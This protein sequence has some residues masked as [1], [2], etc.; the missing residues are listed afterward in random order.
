M[1]NVLLYC[2]VVLIWGPTWIMIKYQLGVVPVEASV[3][4]RFMIAA[5]LMFAWAS[6]WRLP[7]RF[8][9][10][11][12]GF[13]ALQGMLIFSIN[14]YLFYLAGHH[15]ATGLLAVIFSTASAL[16]M[17]LNA[18]RA[19]QRPTLQGMVGA[20]LGT[21]GIGTIFWPE[22]VEVSARSGASTGLA[23]G[24]GG[25]LC[26]ALGGMVSARNHAAGLSVR[27][28]TA[29]AMAYGALLLTCIVVFNGES[30]TFDPRPPYVGS[31]LYL[32]VFG[33]V[34]AFA[35]YFALLG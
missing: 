32:A 8:S 2:A 1:T 5:T 12:H 31:L 29:W 11:D 9:P 4:Y 28:S 16:T 35:C 34:V 6:A 23:L 7:L 13:I 22:L 24:L 21:I 18:I 15:L 20:L 30:F 19:R 25:T 17:V 26:F 3:A 10:R 14:F 27:G 33:S